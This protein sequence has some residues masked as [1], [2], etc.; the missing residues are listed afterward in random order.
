MSDIEK[1]AGRVT[2]PK[3]PERHVIEHDNMR[4]DWRREMSEAAIREATAALRAEIAQRDADDHVVTEQTKQMVEKYEADLAALRTRIGDLEEDQIA[5]KLQRDSL[6]EQ[7][8]TLE[9]SVEELAAGALE[10]LFALPQELAQVKAAALQEAADIMPKREWG[11]DYEIAW[12]QAR[13][14]IREH[15]DTLKRE[16]KNA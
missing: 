13:R 11:S 14:W 8:D 4:A 2:D 5:L 10:N 6:R 15:A 3:N 16:V 9:E 1:T 12:E 7:R